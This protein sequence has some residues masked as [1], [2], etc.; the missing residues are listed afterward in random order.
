MK[1]TYIYIKLAGFNIIE[2]YNPFNKD[3]DIILFNEFNSEN[4]D[5]VYVTGIDITQFLQRET[6]HTRDNTVGFKTNFEA[7]IQKSTAIRV[8]YSKHFA[9]KVIV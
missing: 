4:S 5:H 3:C 7:F 2:I 1:E 6:V 9:Y 8:K